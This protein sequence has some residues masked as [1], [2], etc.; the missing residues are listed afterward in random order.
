MS[1]FFLFKGAALLLLIFGLSSCDSLN[2]VDHEKINT[3]PNSDIP[4]KNRTFDCSTIDYT[5]SNFTY[6]EDM[7]NFHNAFLEYLEG[8]L[9]NYNGLNTEAFVVDVMKDF[10]TINRYEYAFL[11][12]NVIDLEN[13]IDDVNDLT[14]NA[15]VYSIRDGAT[16]TSLMTG[17][18]SNAKDKVEDLGDIFNSYPDT[19]DNTTIQDLI[20]DIKVWESSVAS[21]F[22]I[23]AGEKEKL[24][25]AGMIGR[26]S[27]YYW[28]C[29]IY[30]S[31]PEDWI[32]HSTGEITYRGAFWNWLK[33]RALAIGA[34]DVAGFLLAGGPIGAALSSGGAGAF[35]Y[36][37]DNP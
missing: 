37:Y 36:W 24:M 18:S 30:Y 16:F 29:Y 2:G 32:D 7:G 13:Y 1:Q 26:Y 11:P 6:G 22:S 20:D 28:S 31:G 8:E 3:Y 4:S 15:Y 23:S 9:T 10:A 33:R 35:M 5:N 14:Q 34:F 12:D 25:K 17:Y 19:I 21:S 27:L